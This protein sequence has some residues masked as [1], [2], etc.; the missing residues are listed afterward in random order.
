MD[1]VDHFEVE[2]AVNGSTFQY[3]GTVVLNGGHTDYS[4]EDL[5]AGNGNNLYRIRVILRSGQVKYSN[6][7]SVINSDRQL[8]IT[9]IVPNPVHH[10]ASFSI[11]SAASREVVWQINDASGKTM[12]RWQQHLTIGTN[13][14]S[15]SISEMKA[16]VYFIAG[17]TPEGRT[18]IT[19]FV[20]E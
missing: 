12:K 15:I 17:Y 3:L 9:G 5:G 8:F 20:K 1:E 4:Y 14:L 2:R 18:N 6:T 13:L 19:S 16:G 7:V 10:S 11:N